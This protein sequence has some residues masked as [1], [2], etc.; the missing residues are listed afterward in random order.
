MSTAHDPMHD[1]GSDSPS[2]ARD[3]SDAEHWNRL[4]ESAETDVHGRFGHR[5]MGIPGTWIGALRAL[6]DQ[7]L[8]NSGARPWSEWHYWWQAHYL[9]AIIDAAFSALQ[10]GE[11]STARAE[12]KRAQR[13]LRGVLIRNLAS[14]PNYFYDDMAWLLLAATR[15]NELSLQLSARPALLSTL[16]M[17]ALGRQLVLGQDDKLGGGLYWSR[18]RD[19]KNTPS[20]GP[21]AL[22]FARI[23]DVQ[24]SNRLLAWLRHNL[25]DERTG[26]YLDGIRLTAS[27]PQLENAIYTYNQGT[28]LGALLASGSTEHLAQAQSL[29]ESV[30]VHLS[31]DDHGIGLRLGTG[32]DGDLF[33]GILCRYLALAALDPRLPAASRHTAARLICL[34]AAHLADRTET[35]LSAA[36]QRWTILQ[37]AQRV[38]QAGTQSD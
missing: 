37:A 20:N 38:C 25:H 2:A 26:L 1:P 7:P 36:I 33:T 4:A 16:A 6:P 30:K 15:L 31:N 12:W 3:I 13:L 35:Q 8:P 28:V 21:A 32:G 34:T 5:L 9:D 10:A 18:K 19:F 11:R 22:Y 27:G 17:R 14:F 24:T 29:I 23:N